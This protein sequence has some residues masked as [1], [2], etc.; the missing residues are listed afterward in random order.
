VFF[1][2]MSDHFL[3]VAEHLGVFDIMQLAPNGSILEPLPTVQAGVCQSHIASQADQCPMTL[4]HR[5]NAI[6]VA[7]EAAVDR[8]DNGPEVD[9]SP[10]LPANITLCDAQAQAVMAFAIP[11]SNPRPVRWLIPEGKIPDDLTVRPYRILWYAT[12]PYFAYY[13]TGRYSDVIQLAELVA[14]V[15]TR[16]ER[17]DRVQRAILRTQCLVHLGKRQ[18][19]RGQRED[20]HRR[21]AG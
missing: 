15:Q 4:R 9:M 13:Y 21:S 14:L 8:R 17:E 19:E 5:G 10:A 18:Q 16:P 1:P 6:A 3:F 12:G 11:D 7:I 20:D 2:P